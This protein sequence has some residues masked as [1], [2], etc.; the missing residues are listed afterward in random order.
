MTKYNL[1]NT[2]IARVK[3]CVAFLKRIGEGNSITWQSICARPAT[4]GDF[5]T[6]VEAEAKKRKEKLADNLRSDKSFTTPE[7]QN[8]FAKAARKTF[9][10]RD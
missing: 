10:P 8:A 9:L 2:E 4:A 1:P 3:R 7:S 5:C 6:R